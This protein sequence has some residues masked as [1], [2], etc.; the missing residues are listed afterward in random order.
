MSHY[1]S[2][3]Q[4]L[5]HNISTFFSSINHALWWFFS[6]LLSLYSFLILL[7]HT[8]QI[9]S[10]SLLL[11]TVFKSLAF[12]WSLSYQNSNI[13]VLISLSLIFLFPTSVH[14]YFSSLRYAQNILEFSLF[15]FFFLFWVISNVFQCILWL[16]K[17]N[18][19]F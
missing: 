7:L 2:N 13:Y 19:F 18:D 3:L 15:T 8:F 12:K 16:Y 6:L 9:Y 17:Y 4:S 14:N 5:I 11:S 10:R 1:N